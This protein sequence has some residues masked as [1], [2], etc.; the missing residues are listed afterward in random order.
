LKNIKDLIIIHD[1][2]DLKFG[3]YKIQTNRGTAGHNGVNSIVEYMKTQD[4]TR[5]RIGIYPE[6]IDKKNLDTTKFVLQ[7]LSRTELKNLYTS[8]FPEILKSL[9]I[10]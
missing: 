4:F 8:I 10:L 2:I 7:Q 9:I 3:K 5:V 6:H 1:D